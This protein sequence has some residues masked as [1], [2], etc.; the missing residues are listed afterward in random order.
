[1]RFKRLLAQKN[2]SIEGGIEM[3]EN[4]CSFVDVAITCVIFFLAE[5]GKEGKEK[6]GRNSWR[7]RASQKVGRRDTLRLVLVG[8]VLQAGRKENLEGI[9]PAAHTG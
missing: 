9:G 1:M 6:G 7:G 5:G 8:V 3:K 2:I 4:I